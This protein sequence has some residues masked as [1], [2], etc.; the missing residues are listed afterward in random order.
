MRTIRIVIA[1]MLPALV[2][3]GGKGKGSEDAVDD[4]TPVDTSGEDVQDDGDADGGEGVE[5]GT[6]DSPEDTPADTAEEEPASTELRFANI[7]C[8]PDVGSGESVVDGQ[9]MFCRF[10]VRG[11]SGTR[12][13]LECEDDTGSPIDCGSSS[14]T[15]IQP[16][17]SNPLPIINGWFGTG[18]SGRAGTTIVVVWVADDTVDQARHRFEADVVADDGVNGP[19]SIEVTCAGDSD[20]EVGVAAGARLD[21]TLRFLDPDPD[22]LTWDYVQTSGP[23]PTSAPGP[24]SGLGRAPFDVTWRWQTATGES[25]TYVYTFSVDDG[26][27]S[28]A[29]FDLTVNVS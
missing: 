26:T 10:E 2:A 5:D 4:E 20:G 25:G 29:T 23:A 18:T 19:P 6:A 27:S 15:Q 22:D 11:G 28:P 12:A 24:Y 7:R 3:C 14:T 1:C 9:S 13:T 17:G 8:L 16:F 21:C